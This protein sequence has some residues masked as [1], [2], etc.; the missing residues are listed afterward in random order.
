[1]SGE[2]K[3]NWVL[4][5]SGEKY[6][7][8]LG[9]GTSDPQSSDEKRAASAYFILDGLRQGLS[10]E[11]IVQVLKGFYWIPGPVP[12]RF[13]AGSLETFERKGWVKEAESEYTDIPEA[14]KDF[15]EHF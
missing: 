7:E 6:L 10:L 11:E 3:K 14:F 1:M 8:S 4:T 9:L 5:S 15:K 2:L 12:Y 13:L